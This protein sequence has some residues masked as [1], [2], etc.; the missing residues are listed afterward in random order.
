M[1]EQEI[2]KAWKENDR[3]FASP[4]ITDE[5]REWAKNHWKDMW[6][7][8]DA[9]SWV[10]NNMFFY[11]SNTYRLRP[12]YQ[13]DVKEP[14]FEYLEIT[15]H[16]RCARKMYTVCDYIVATDAPSIVGFEGYTSTKNECEPSFPY[17]HPD[18]KYVK[19][20]KDAK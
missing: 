12:D 3:Y 13:P 7:A 18:H 9:D 8:D 6:R 10:G 2:I 16:E 19:I 20:R 15:I 1:T 5:M 14:E 4:N 11:G 17:F